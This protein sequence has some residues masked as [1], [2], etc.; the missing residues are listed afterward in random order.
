MAAGTFWRGDDGKVWVAG[1]NGVNS[2]GTW[3]ANSGNYW[4]NK[5]YR[6]ELD[7]NS[8]QGYTDQLVNAGANWIEKADG[9]SGTTSGGTAA[10]DPDAGQ[11]A[12]LKSRIGGRGGEIDA[13]YNALF[14]DLNALIRSRDSELETQYGDQL[15]SATGKFEEAL[16][17]I[18]TSYAALGS[19]DSTQR[20]D[21]RGKAKT[22]YE[23][24]TKTIGNNKNKDKAALGQYKRENEAKFGADRDSAKRAIQSAAETT[25]VGALRGLDNDLSSN[26]SQAGVTRA[27]LGSDGAARQSVSALTSDNGRYDSAINALDSILKGSMSSDVKAAAVKAVTDA[28]GLSEEEKKKVQQT[29]GNVYAEQAAL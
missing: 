16:P 8:S 15:K 25:D 19:Y 2:A 10:A 17:A 7:P 12:A 11:R 26:I 20:T 27:T 22:G 14:S 18:D 3:D 29:Y 23:E 21:S 24:T 28:G 5:G 1:A 4:Q 13:I 9:G 6:L